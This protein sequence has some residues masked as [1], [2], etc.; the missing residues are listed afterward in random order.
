MFKIYLNISAAT[1]KKDALCLEAFYKAG[2]I[3]GRHVVAV[4]PNADKVN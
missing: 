1:E 3:L 4:L 2:H